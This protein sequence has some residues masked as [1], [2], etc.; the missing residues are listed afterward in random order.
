MHCACLPNFSTLLF[1]RYQS[2]YLVASNTIDESRRH[3]ND[4]CNSIKECPR[5]FQIRRCRCCR[6]AGKVLCSHLAEPFC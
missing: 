6:L 5:E 1:V 4:T 3:S 2:R